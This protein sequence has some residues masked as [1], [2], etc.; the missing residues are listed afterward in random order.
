MFVSLPPSIP[1]L[2]LSKDPLTDWLS[3]TEMEKREYSLSCYCMS[4]C[5]REMRLFPGFPIW[6]GHAGQH[7]GQAALLLH[8]SEL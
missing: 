8:V 5:E 6:R 7:A 2:V 1:W 4:V 3:H